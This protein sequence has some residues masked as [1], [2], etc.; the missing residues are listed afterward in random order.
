M[1]EK[2]PLTP[3]KARYL[4]ANFIGLAMIASVFLYAG[5]VEILKRVWDPF[6][7]FGDLSPQFAE[8]LRHVLLGVAGVIYFV[9]L[10]GQRRLVARNRELLPHATFLA[11]VLAELVALF[12]LMLFLLT[13]KSL[14]FYVF[15]AVSLL[16]F[17]VYFPKYS[18]WEAIL[19]EGPEESP[20]SQ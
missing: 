6:T 4:V 15:F 7:G 5:V 19:G 20:P 10:F 14:D 13:G 18:T 12:G 2:G 16:Y 17:W 11:Y 8:S 1:T 9:I 3:L